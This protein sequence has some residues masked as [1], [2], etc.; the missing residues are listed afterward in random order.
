MERVHLESR[1]VF[2]RQAAVIANAFVAYAPDNYRYRISIYG[3][4]LTD[5]DIRVGALNVVF[6]QTYFHRPREFGVE[7][8]LNF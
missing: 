4:N 5:D 6:I 2:Y 3:K 8:Q 1:P 7:A